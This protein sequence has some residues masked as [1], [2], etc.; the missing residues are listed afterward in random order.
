MTDLQN[1][2]NQDRPPFSWDMAALV[3]LA[4]L[5]NGVGA[6]WRNRHW[7]N[8]QARHRASYIGSR[9]AVRASDLIVALRNERQ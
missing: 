2:T 7:Y 3:F 6:T 8:G 9:D 5:F 4:V 1:P